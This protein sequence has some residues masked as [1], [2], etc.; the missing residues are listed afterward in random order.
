MSPSSQWNQSDEADDRFLTGAARQPEGDRF[1]AGA[2][3]QPPAAPPPVDFGKDWRG[4]CCTMPP[5]EVEPRTYFCTITC[6]GTWL[7]GDQRGSVDRS[8]NDWL[9][10]PLAPD[11][12]RER[13]EFARLKHVPVKLEYGQRVIVQATIED[14]CRCRG[15]R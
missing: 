9:T 3:R 8:H 14:V 10:P 2:V 12:E 1:L 13:R 6:Y 5:A 15:W 11:E 7:H 4:A